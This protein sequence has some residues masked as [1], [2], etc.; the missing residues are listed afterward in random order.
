MF[1]RFQEKLNSGEWCHIFPEGRVWQS[2]RFE[3][4]EVKLLIQPPLIAYN[5]SILLFL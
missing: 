2:W 4:D 5:K 3:D 1:L